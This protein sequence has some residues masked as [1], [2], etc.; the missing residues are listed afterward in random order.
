MCHLLN[1]GHLQQPQCYKFYIEV[2][3]VQAL[4]I[5]RC[6]K[7]GSIME[8]QQCNPSLRLHHYPD[9]KVHGANMGPIWSRQDPGGPH[10]G[11]MNFAIWVAVAV[12]AQTIIHTY[13]SQYK[14]DKHCIS[15]YRVRVKLS[16]RESYRWYACTT[17]LPT[18]WH[19]PWWNIASVDGIGLLLWT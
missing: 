1:C 6:S 13:A 10:V 4:I 5:S 14:I 2:S 17:I 7:N 12:K 16:Q 18:A 8:R 11:P 3:S 9:S 19:I 15:D